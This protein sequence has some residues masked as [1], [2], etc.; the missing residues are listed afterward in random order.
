MTISVNDKVRPVPTSG[1]GLRESPPVPTESSTVNTRIFF[2]DSFTYRLNVLAAAAID[3][4]EAAFGT[5]IGG[6]IRE[7]RVLRIVDDHPGIGF[8]EI[9]RA[10][11][12][13][14]SLVSRLIQ[15]LLKQGLIERRAAPDDA[16]R[17]ELHATDLGQRKRAG[18]QAITA[19]FESLILKPLSPEQAAALEEALEVLAGWVGSDAYEEEVEALRAELAR[20]MPPLPAAE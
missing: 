12:L 15:A 11:R 14:R 5:M 7:M 8:A 17:F 13:D 19:A 9:V 18:A 4:G 6:S 20:S 3:S 16:R 10:T 1:A 2:N